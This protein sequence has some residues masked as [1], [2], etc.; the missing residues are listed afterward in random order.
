MSDLNYSKQLTGKKGNQESNSW[1]S[2]NS[3][4]KTTWD[5]FI[6]G[7]IIIKSIVVAN[8]LA[9][10]NGVTH[11]KGKSVSDLIKL[12]A[13]DMTVQFVDI[14]FT[15]FTAF[16]DEQEGLVR[17]KNKIAR[18]YLSSWFFPDLFWALPIRITVL[19]ANDLDY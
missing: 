4:K 16:F 3:K 17:D 7:Y 9:F 8:N 13:F 5:I 10:D 19:I 14:V 11:L 1:I 6:M 12:C 15:F 18:E 2:P